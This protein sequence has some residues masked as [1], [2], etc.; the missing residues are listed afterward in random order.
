MT[1]KRISV[2]FRKESL[3]GFVMATLDGNLAPTGDYELSVYNHDYSKAVELVLTRDQLALI[4][5]EI[6]AY[7]GEGE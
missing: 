7:I 4:K 1:N 3:S 5:D 6:D 2:D